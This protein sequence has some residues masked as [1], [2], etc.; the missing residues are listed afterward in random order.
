M[1]DGDRSIA[2]SGARGIYFSIDLSELRSV[3]SSI[4]A[5]NDVELAEQGFLILCLLG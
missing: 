1:R 3:R 2:A 5:K 4:S